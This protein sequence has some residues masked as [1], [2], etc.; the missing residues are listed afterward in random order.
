MDATN[1]PRTV[2][3]IS[4]RAKIP[5]DGVV[6][7]TTSKSTNWSKG[8]SPFFLG[9]IELYDGY[10]SQNFENAW[11]FCKTYAVH[12]D[13]DGN[14][15]Q[16]Y[17]DWARAGWAKS[18]AVRYPMGRGARPL[19]SLWEGK[20]LGYVDAR[21]QIYCQLYS[22]AVEITPAWE[23]LVETYNQCKDNNTV[24]YL[25][26]YDGYDMKNKT[27]SDVINDPTRK[28]GHA[29]V[30]AMLLEDAREW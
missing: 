28:M 23:Q 15:T 7:D 5:T 9:P 10:V 16:E 14:P 24:L 20:R 18:E 12:A 13:A 4:H 29:F 26:D 25:R 22:E 11:Q 6:V 17:W 30:L 19:Y 8:L 3:V 2:K 21:K 27:Y 1:R